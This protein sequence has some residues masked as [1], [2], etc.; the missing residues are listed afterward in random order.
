MIDF[1]NLYNV[2][3]ETKINKGKTSIK[4]LGFEID[5]PATDIR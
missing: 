1:L 5:N 3:N 4:Y 2:V